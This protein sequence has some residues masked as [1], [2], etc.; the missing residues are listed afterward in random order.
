MKS[1]GVSAELSDLEHECS[2]DSHSPTW[3]A[4]ALTT[5]HVTLISTCYKASDL[6]LHA[7]CLVAQSC[8]TLC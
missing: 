3:T 6:I 1:I 2:V 4:R 5:Y 8:L 7:A